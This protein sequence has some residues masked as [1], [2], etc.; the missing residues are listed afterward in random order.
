M[1][2]VPEN[3]KTSVPM[4]GPTSANRTT[5][6]R[7]GFIRTG[8]ISKR[9][10]ERERRTNYQGKRRRSNEG[11]VRL[12]ARSGAGWELG[13]APLVLAGNTVVVTVHFYAG[14]VAKE[15]LRFRT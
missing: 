12:T 11:G 8:V 14:T 13:T 4:P 15:E 3:K 10:R 6:T 7:Y 5:G 9:E 2:P 1:T